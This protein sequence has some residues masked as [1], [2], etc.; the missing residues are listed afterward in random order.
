MKNTKESKANFGFSPVAAE[1]K[2]GL[3]NEVFARV[4][5][6]YVG[7]PGQSPGGHARFPGREAATTDRAGSCAPRLSQA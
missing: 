7:G 5:R 6:R 4:A 1:A 3:V 2:Q